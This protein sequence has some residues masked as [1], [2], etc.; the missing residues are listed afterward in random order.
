ML[1]AVFAFHGKII[2]YSNEFV[3]LP[4][5]E[6]NFLPH[7]WT[8]AKPA[9]EHWLFNFIF[10][11][12]MRVFSL[13]TAGWLGRIA[14]WCLCLAALLKIGRLW[15][16]PFWAT[17]VSIFLW[18]ALGQ[19]VVGEEWI[20]GGFEAKTVAYVCLLFALDGFAGKKIILSSVLLGLSFSF[21]PAVGL[22]AVLAVGA[23]L[24]FE[25]IPT[26]DFAK[27]VFI[28]AFFSL[29]ALL[30]IFTEQTVSN[31]NL[32]DDWRYIVLFRAPANL[33]PFSF[34]KSGTFLL[35]AMLVFNFFALEKCESFALRFL[36]KFQIALGI[37]FLLGLFLRWFEL[38]PLLRFMPMRLF[39]V[40]TLLFFIFTAFYIV[41]R[42]ASRQHKLIVSLF[43]AAIIVL[44]NPFGKGLA[45]IRETVQS[46]TAPRDDFQKA[47]LAIAEKTPK[48]SLIIEPPNRRDAWYFSKRATIVSF[49]YPTYDR[50]T[51]WRG[52]IAELT[53]NLQVSRGDTAGEE[54]ETA[55]N[56]LSEAQIHKI[57][58]KYGAS[59]LVSRAVYS[60]PIV[61]ETETYKVYELPL[62]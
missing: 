8:F 23:A 18:L 16:I 12:P 51:E 24:L 19:S 9:N 58:Q 20:F 52:R 49:Y 59:Y 45:Q 22:W 14:V 34:S 17:A 48:D 30:A 4:R 39:P 2:P 29:P 3:Y 28:T 26:L 50:L 5:L 13:E 57:K 56:R 62:E 37:F 32:F 40:F 55:F 1:L 42:L 31:V 33:D 15:R 46:R 10:S 43:A 35:Y 60:Y 38:Y 36:L 7:D 61:F 11:L 27:V 25:K 53:D 44:L 6:P 54:I 47:A 41:P 21:H